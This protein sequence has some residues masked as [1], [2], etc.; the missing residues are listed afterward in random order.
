MPLPHRG[1]ATL[2]EDA[3]IATSPSQYAPAEC[4]EQ[5]LPSPQPNLS[6]KAVISEN[7]FSIPVYLPLLGPSHDRWGAVGL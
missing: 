6:T 5:K 3:D 1:I 2:T 7:F 4:L